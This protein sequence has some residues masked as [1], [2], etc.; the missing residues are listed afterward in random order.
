MIMRFRKN[1]C[2][3]HTYILKLHIK[4]EILP[5]TKRRS[6][7]TPTKHPDFLWQTSIPKKTYYIEMQQSGYF[8][9]YSA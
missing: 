1:M 7:F 5:R 8:N 6:N 2:V 3:R 4:D 9:T